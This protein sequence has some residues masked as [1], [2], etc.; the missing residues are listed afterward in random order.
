MSVSC[1]TLI[2]ML[3]RVSSRF[4]RNFFPEHTTPQC[5]F[6]VAISLINLNSDNKTNNLHSICADNQIALDHFSAFKGYFSFFR[7]ATNNIC[8]CLDSC[9]TP[10]ALWCSRKVLQNCM[11]VYPVIDN[12]VLVQLALN[13]GSD[14]RQLLTPPYSFFGNNGTFVWSLPSVEYMRN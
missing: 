13:L 7:L 1:I 2:E 9:R 11:E 5:A 12:S 8:R 3:T 10:K 6:S 14:W 4:G